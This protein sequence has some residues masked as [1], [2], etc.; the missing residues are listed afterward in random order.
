[1]QNA[2]KNGEHMHFRLNGLM[3][4]K[5]LKM[6]VFIYLVTYVCEIYD[7]LNRI[8]VY[9]TIYLNVFALHFKMYL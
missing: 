8:L 5:I 9:F 7:K 6:C 1:M 4:V 3:L 2:G